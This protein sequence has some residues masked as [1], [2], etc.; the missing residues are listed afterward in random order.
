MAEI[1]RPGPLAKLL[2]EPSED[3]QVQE[4][5][6]EVVEKICGSYSYGG[7]RERNNSPC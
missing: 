4:Q 3:P 6:I 2:G 1:T 7:E 5:L